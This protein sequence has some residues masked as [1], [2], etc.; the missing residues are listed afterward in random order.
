MNQDDGGVP[1]ISVGKPPR[2]EQRVEQVWVLVAIHPDGGEGIYGQKI[3]DL[4]Q[5]FVVSDLELKDMLEDYL[6][7]KGS[8]AVARREGIVLEWRQMALVG[9]AVQIT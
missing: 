9:E 5:S 6:R 8:V 7:G 4:L 2:P 3:G 1:H